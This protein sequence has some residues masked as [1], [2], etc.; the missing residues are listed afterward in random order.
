MGHMPRCAPR[1]SPEPKKVNLFLQPIWLAHSA[2]IR[3]TQRALVICDPR[4]AATRPDAVRGTQRRPDRTRDRTRPATSASPAADPTRAPGR[5]SAALYTE[6]D[7]PRSCACMAA[8]L[9]QH[10]GT[11]ADLFRRAMQP[12]GD[13]EG[14]AAAAGRGIGQPCLPISKKLC[15]FNDLRPGGPETVFSL[16]YRLRG[17]RLGLSGM[18]H[19]S[20]LRRLRNRGGGSAERGGSVPGAAHGDPTGALLRRPG[21]LRG[22]R[23]GP[24]GS[25]LE[26]ARLYGCVRFGHR[27]TGL[28][29]CFC[30]RRACAF[31][32]RLPGWGDSLMIKLIFFFFYPYL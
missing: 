12:Q 30:L 14:L 16:Q 2:N 22:A 8:M 25:R 6:P 29:F 26:P 17:R 1:Q 7:S 5:C 23:S 20:G 31:V 19:Q 10:I 15:V 3:G 4:L 21:E 18:P 28:R 9:R 32:F 13:C 11:R 27:H 24:C